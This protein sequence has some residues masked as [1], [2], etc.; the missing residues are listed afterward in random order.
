[1]AWAARPPLRQA[2]RNPSKRTKYRRSQ[3]GDDPKPSRSTLQRF[4]IYIGSPKP[5]LHADERADPLAGEITDYS[6]IEFIQLSGRDPSR[7]K[8]TKAAGRFIRSISSFAKLS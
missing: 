7:E 5:R 4:S 3:A 2:K 6:S 8:F 1:M